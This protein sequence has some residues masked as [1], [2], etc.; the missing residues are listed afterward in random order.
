VNPIGSSVIFLSLVNGSSREELNKLATKIGMYTAILLIVMLLIG[1]VILRFFGITIPIVLIGG[2][3]VI[4]Y[5][6][7]Q[8]LNQP[9]IQ[10]EKRVATTD[11]DQDRDQMAFYPLTMPVT[12][13]PGCIAVAIAVGAHSISPSWR[14]TFLSQLGNIIGI[15]IIGVTVVFCYRYA[16]AITKKLGASGTQV[17]MRLAAFINLCIGLEIMWHGIQYLLPK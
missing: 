5:I 1:S 16:Y 6:G 3:L 10:G 11:I 2:G 13:G 4:A 17:I 12:A 7:W 8:L 9:E 14:V 15:L